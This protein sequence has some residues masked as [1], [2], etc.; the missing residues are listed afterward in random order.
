MQMVCFGVLLMLT[1]TACKKDKQCKEEP[2]KIW[3]IIPAGT[4]TGVW[5][6]L[7]EDALYA[8]LT[9]SCPSAYCASVRL[10][11]ENGESSLDMLQDAELSVVADSVAAQLG[12][13]YNVAATNS[14]TLDFAASTNDP[15]GYFAKTLLSSKLRYKLRSVPATDTR[16]RAE[17]SI[18]F[19]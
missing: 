11:L 18:G 1:A 9:C 10:Y 8:N 13:A 4:S 5:Q 19:N 17:I 2:I 15:R 16:V 7:R 3:F 6:E 14:K 12:T